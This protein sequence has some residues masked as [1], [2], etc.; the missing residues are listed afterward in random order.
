MI[1]ERL[2]Q[3]TGH[4]FVYLTS[5]GDAAIKAALTNF[6]QVLIPEEGGWLSYKK[7][8]HELVKC[9]DAKIDLEDLKNKVNTN[10]FDA[11][12]YQN[13]GGYFA[14][15]PMKEIYE[16][17]KN[18]CKVVI[19][20]SG[21]IGTILCDGKYAD[22][23]VGSF[24]RWKL[25][26]AGEGG[27]IS[28]N[29]RL[30]VNEITDKD[31]LGKIKVALVNLNGRINYLTERR[32]RIINDLKDY[33]ILFRDDLGFVVVIDGNEEKVI[34]YCKMNNLEYTKCPRY[35]RVNKEA[36]SIEVKRL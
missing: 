10:T 18:K 8:P 13:T 32:K 9:N 16:I 31:L 30:E 25:V 20:V 35:I 22:I 21:S 2:K 29:E 1:T 6:R 26:E 14:E 4:K 27:F 3:L 11:F 33:N 36:I 15:Q 5:R 34:N 24:G 17:C 23:F 19:D 12:L 28:T 7:F